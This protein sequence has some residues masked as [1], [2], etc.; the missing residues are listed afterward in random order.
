MLGSRLDDLDPDH[1]GLDSRGLRLGVDLDAAHARGLQQDGVAKVAERRCVV[2]GALGRDAQSGCAGSLD[3]GG[4]V[5]GGFGE[6]DGDRSLVDGEVPGL[7]GLVPGLVGRRDD[8]PGEPRAQRLRVEARLD[9]VEIHLLHR[10]YLLLWGGIPTVA[11]ARGCAHRPRGRTRLV[12][13]DDLRLVPAK[14]ADTR[15]KT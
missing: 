9:L 13:P 5:G 12:G 7:T 4:D 10:E 14:D 6:H 8:V 2:A 3:R 15:K 11:R 1:A